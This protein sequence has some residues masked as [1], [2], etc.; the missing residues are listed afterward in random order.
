MLH[1]LR[2]VLI[3]LSLALAALPARAFETAAT[4]AWVYDMTTGTVLMDKNADQPLPPASMSKLMTITMLFEALK[5]GRV[6]METEFAV[7]SRAKAMGGSTMFLQETDR[8]T[9]SDLIH[10]MII[11]SGN[12]ACVVVAEGLAG[13]EEAFAD[14]M[15]ERS[16]A[17]GM[18]NS[19]FANASGWPDPNHRMSMRDL[20]ILTQHL[21]EDFPEY[22]PVFAETEYNYK[23]RAPDNRFNRN[24]LL[25][26]GIGADGLKTGHTSEAG[27][28]LV[29]SAKQGDRRVI[30][31]ITGLA[32]E[33]AR[34]EEAERIVGW[35]FRQFSEKT[36]AKTGIRVTEAE[37][38]LGDAETVGLVPAEDVR[39]LVPALVQDSVTAEVVYNGPLIAPVI[40]GSPVA[41]LIVHVPDL[42][43]RRFPLVAEADVGTAGFFK[44]LTTA[45]KQLYGQYIGSPAS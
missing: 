18:T 25:T 10:G 34:A 24:P 33:Q 1:R 28:G 5:D 39:L 22:Y 43:D 17:L 11:N 41:E 4:A 12:D 16:R 36:V 45:G 15:T 27:Y 6:T 13:T 38:H 23:D 19:V 20:G 3:L 40:K 32:S 2:P 14:Q 31:V 8:P 26:L 35:A 30:F 7:S 37:V 42:P 9:V 44:R 21:I 29:G